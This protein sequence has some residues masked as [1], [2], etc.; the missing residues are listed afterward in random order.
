MSHTGTCGAN[1]C[2]EA[3]LRHGAYKMRNNLD[4]ADCQHVNW[5]SG[6]YGADN[7]PKGALRRGGINGPAHGSLAEWTSCRSL[8]FTLA[9]ELNRFM[10]DCGHS[11]R[12]RGE[13]ARADL[14]IPEEE[15]RESDDG[16]YQWSL[17]TVLETSP[18]VAKRVCRLGRRAQ[19]A[20]CR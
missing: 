20:D 10:A 1:L 15:L 19:V 3:T 12:L 17:V 4:V 8:L 11:G 13:T 6:V 7:A 2:L 5:A 18:A 14:V 16:D 9:G